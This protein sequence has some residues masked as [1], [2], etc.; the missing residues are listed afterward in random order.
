MNNFM[1]EVV[2]AYLKTIIR[3][4]G[5]RWISPRD[6]KD[7][8]EC[9]VMEVEL[10]LTPDALNF[11]GAFIMLL[12]RYDPRVNTDHPVFQY[13]GERAEERENAEVTFLISLKER[14]PA[15]AEKNAT[16]V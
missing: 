4:V 7:D 16:D 6:T 1:K 2:K 3:F 14:K 10:D 12:A 5:A 13:L 8:P 11:L 15:E 9:A